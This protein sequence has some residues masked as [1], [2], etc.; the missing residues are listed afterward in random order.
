MLRRGWIK[1][2]CGGE[3]GWLDGTVRFQMT[4][5]QRSIWVDLLALCGNSRY[6]DEGVIAAG[7]NSDGSLVPFPEQYLLG[8]VQVDA[9]T[10]RDTLQLLV[11]QERITLDSSGA[12]RITNWRRYQSEYARVLPYRKHGATDEHRIPEHKRALRKVLY[13]VKTGRIVRPTVCSKCGKP[14]SYNDQIQAHHLDYTKPY[15]IAWLCEDCRMEADAMVNCHCLSCHN[16]KLRKN[17]IKQEEIQRRQED[18]TGNVTPGGVTLPPLSV[19]S[20]QGERLHEKNKPEVI[21]LDAPEVE[22]ISV[23][24]PPKDLGNI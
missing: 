2:Y 22:D 8:I 19:V 3:G 12:I 6:P 7:K 16:D 5:I 11:Q 1:V 14:D 17:K 21:H 4:P 23:A 20:P 18:I 15:D 9:Q 10:F 13:A 24:A